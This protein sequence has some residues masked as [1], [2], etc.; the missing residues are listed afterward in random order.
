MPPLDPPLFPDADFAL[1]PHEREIDKILRLA[2]AAAA[3]QVLAADGKP[4]TFRVGSGFVVP[5]ENNLSEADVRRLADEVLDGQGRLLLEAEGDIEVEMRR[6][7]ST[8][9]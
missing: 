4:L 1:H 3:S 8:S 5:A 2:F 6:P 9:T 7:R